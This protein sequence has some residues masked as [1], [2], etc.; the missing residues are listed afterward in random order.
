MSGET[1]WPVPWIYFLSGLRGDKV[2]VKLQRFEFM[3]SFVQK[4]R[5]GAF[6]A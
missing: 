3:L 1:Y 4:E 2:I 5:M 6:T